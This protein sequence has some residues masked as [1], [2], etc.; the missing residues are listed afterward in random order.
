[1][2]D[3]LIC[4]NYQDFINEIKNEIKLFEEIQIRCQKKL[5]MAKAYFPTNTDVKILEDE[6]TSLHKSAMIGKV[7]QER[8]FYIL[9]TLAMFFSVLIFFQVWSSV[10]CSNNFYFIYKNCVNTFCLFVKYS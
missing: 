4:K 1:M 10:L 3:Y 8:Y 5:S 9:I 7:V 6:F 2:S